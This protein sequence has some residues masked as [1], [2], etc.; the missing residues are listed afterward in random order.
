MLTH[1]SKANE[2]ARNHGLAQF[3]V[4]QGRWSAAQR[5]FERDIIPMARDE[6]MA[7]APWGAL[8]GGTFKTEQQ[9]TSKEGRSVPSPEEAV[10]VSRVLEDIADEKGTVITSV[11]LA[12][13]M[14][15]SPYVFP[16]VGG[17]S[18]GHLR[19]N[20]EA[21]T[22]RLGAEEIRRI[23]GAVPFEL[24]FPHDFLWKGGVPENP[25]EVWLTELAGKTDHVPLPRPIG[26]AQE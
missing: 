20:I 17:R 4:Y 6:K 14:H 11:A 2:Y 8:G 21:L 25:A 13:V 16:I 26:P 23:E 3:S 10:R 5:D 7:L 15:K 12:Y 24:G 1:N 19:Q 9:R 18:V 22:L